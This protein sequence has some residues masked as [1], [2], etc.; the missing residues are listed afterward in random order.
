MAVIVLEFPIPNTFTQT[1]AGFLKIMRALT[2]KLR[3]KNS[4]RTSIKSDSCFRTGF[5]R[6]E[7]EVDKLL[8]DSCKN[9]NGNDEA[10]VYDPP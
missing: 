4:N 6:S 8:L 7:L 5:T 10:I 2:I 9:N 3:T 1:G